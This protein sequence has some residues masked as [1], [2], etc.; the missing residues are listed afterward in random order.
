[1]SC[2]PAGRRGLRQPTNNAAP[3]SKIKSSRN[4]CEKTPSGHISLSLRKIFYRPLQLRRDLR[5]VGARH[6]LNRFADPH[7]Y[8][9]RRGKFT[10]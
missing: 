3:G 9:P 8:L 2:L 10:A 1:M 4:S 7:F 6:E 5:H